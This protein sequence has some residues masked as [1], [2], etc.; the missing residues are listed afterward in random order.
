MSKV[1]VDQTVWLSPLVPD[2]DFQIHFRDDHINITVGPNYKTTPRQR[3]EFWAA[4]CGASEQ[5][6][7]LRILIEGYR[8]KTELSAAEVID[9]GQ[10]ASAS[11]RLWIAFCLDDLYPADQR[12]LFE[13][14]AASRGVRAKFFTDREK[15]LTWLRRNAR[16]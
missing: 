14:V 4:V 10:H 7:S 1:K 6:S 13:V 3:K 2:K 15:A 8:P 16:T 9:A 12:E 5:H 11:P